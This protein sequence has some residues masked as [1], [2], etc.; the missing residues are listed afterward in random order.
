[1]SSFFRIYGKKNTDELN[2]LQGIPG[3]NME[4]SINTL[5]TLYDKYKDIEVFKTNVSEHKKKL[6]TFK[7]ARKYHFISDLVGGQKKYEENLA[8]IRDLELQLATL[9]EEVE[10]G[11]SEEEIE[12][13]KK[14]AALTNEKLMVEKAI[15]AKEMKLRLVS[16]SLEYG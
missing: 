7:E 11:H 12:L 16:M 9:M 10:K 13:N 8:T 2:P 1:M 4:K 5:L 3:Q 14:K 6:D 15:H